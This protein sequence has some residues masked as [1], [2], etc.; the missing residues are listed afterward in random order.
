MAGKAGLKAGLIG[1]AALF[2]LTLV[3][4]VSALAPGVPIGCVCCAVQFLAYAGVGVAAGLFLAPP[5][6][7]GTGAGAGALAGA[8]SGAGA[9]IGTTISGIIQLL[10]GLSAMQTEQ[11]MR[12][13]GDM[14][15]VRPGMLPA[16]ATPS[17]GT[18]AISGTICCFAS[19]AIGAALGAVG[20]AILG[21]A[22]QD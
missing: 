20:G 14:G 21:A 11:L 2:I 22:K 9:G 18:V 12:Q 10:T 8:I 7:A 19:L 16:A 5:R 1:A 4:L 17:L 3:N 15:L 6:S 13:F